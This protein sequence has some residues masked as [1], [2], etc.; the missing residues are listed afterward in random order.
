M[1]RLASSFRLA[2]HP[3]LLAAAAVLIFVQFWFFLPRSLE[4]Q[5][6]TVS[7]ATPSAQE[8]AG[9]SGSPFKGFE[10]PSGS[11]PDYTLKG[12]NYIS[13]LRGKRQWQIK[14]QEAEVYSAQ[15]WVYSRQ[16]LADLYSD[17]QTPA[18][19]VEGQLARYNINTKNLEIGGNVVARF[20][21]GSILRTEFLEYLASEKKVIIPI[22]YR[23][24]GAGPTQTPERLRFESSGMDGN[25][26]SGVFNLKSKVFVE[27]L[28][29]DSRTPPTRAWSSSGIFFRSEERLELQGS[30]PT[31]GPPARMEQGTLKATA[32]QMEA[33]MTSRDQEKRKPSFAAWDDVKIEEW[34]K[35]LNQGAP[36]R[37]S[38]SGR[39]EFDPESQNV[40]LTEFPQVYQEGD[41]MTGEVIRIRR[42]EDLVEV[43]NS[44][45]FTTGE[46]F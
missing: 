16:V 28:G 33:R 30:P 26:I 18:L 4:P 27:M 17:E 14:G 39:A 3:F 38:T 31:L 9:Q 12:L 42:K 2:G 36:D 19:K 40:V 32:L 21:D 43:E 45:A 25:L 23:V 11:S 20:A 37:Y 35:S 7:E 1:P 10:P 24:L 29:R 8:L 44:N 15:Q 46:K 41:T 5:D 22:K 34:K 13:V 6:P